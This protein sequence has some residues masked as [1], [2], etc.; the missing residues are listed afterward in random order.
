[1]TDAT[2]APGA[3]LDRKLDMVTCSSSF[4]NALLASGLAKVGNPPDAVAS[5]RFLE[6]R[7]WGKPRRSPLRI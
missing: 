4:A 2:H 3:A 6:G 5:L 1:M 7:L